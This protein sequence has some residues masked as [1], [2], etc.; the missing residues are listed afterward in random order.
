MRKRLIEIDSGPIIR[1]PDGVYRGIPYAAPRV[2]DL[3]WKPPQP[4]LHWTD[5][6][7]CNTFRPICPQMNYQGAMSE[8]CLYLNIWTP[9]QDAEPKLPVMVWIHGGVFTIGSGSDELYD[10]AALL[11]MLWSV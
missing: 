8:D 10:G 4:A 1:N 5:P 2:E 3:R 9:D 6:L 11:A 7:R